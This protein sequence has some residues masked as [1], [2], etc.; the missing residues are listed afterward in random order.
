[1]ALMAIRKSILQ[2]QVY[3]F[4]KKLFRNRIGGPLGDNKPGCPDCDVWVHIS[5]HEAPHPS[6]TEWVNLL[7]E[8][9][10]DDL[11]QGNK[12][13]PFG[14]NYINGKLF[15]PGIGWTGLFFNGEKLTRDQMRGTE[16]RSLLKCNLPQPRTQ[17][18]LYSVRVSERLLIKPCLRVSKW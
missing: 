13:H 3:M 2:N 11:N 16:D 9:Y 15:W 10:A 12:L 6:P 18:E 1:M 17:E 7:F 14:S 8:S 4:N 5:L